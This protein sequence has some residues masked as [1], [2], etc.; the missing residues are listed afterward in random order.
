MK[1][2]FTSLLTFPIIL[3]TFLTLIISISLLVIFTEP[4]SI[5]TDNSEVKI[6]HGA[7]LWQ[8]AKILETRQMISNRNSFVFLTKL[9]FSQKKLKSGFYDLEGIKTTNQL[10][11]LLLK[12]QNLSTKITIPEGS[13]AKEIAVIIS[14][15]IN[16]DE[17]QFLELCRDVSFI[18]G[19]N[20]ET[21]SL[22][23]YLFPDTYF[24]YKNDVEKTIIEK[25]VKNFKEKWLNIT[26]FI[27][28][29]SGKNQHEILTLASLIEGECMLDVERP[30]VSSL[31]QNRLKRG[32]KLE[33]DP[34]VQYIISDGPR[35]LLTKDL[36]IDSP[37]NTYMY[38]GLPPGPVNNPGEKSIIAAIMPEE[39]KYIYMVAQG[40]GSHF[41]S[42]NYNS[43][44]Q[45]KKR[46]QKVRRKYEG[47]N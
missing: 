32:M 21:E 44:L 37:Y 47:M 24:F 46:F 23:G 9:K 31:Y 18:D 43:F 6:P 27:P 15:H 41:F 8:I 16:I 10:I 28:N 40:D 19:L 25:M 36:K 42:K 20:L 2:K 7:S 13:T 4:V 35:R 17:S 14:P 45:A 1:N 39:T 29:N 22:E 38:K 33:S 12:G 34:T 3:S 26:N 11:N 5:S 30:N